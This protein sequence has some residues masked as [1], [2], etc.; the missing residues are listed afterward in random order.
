[1]PFGLF[2][3]LTLDEL[4]I[5]HQFVL[6]DNLSF[7]CGLRNIVR[8]FAINAQKTFFAHHLISSRIQDASS[9]FHCLRS[10]SSSLS[11][12]SIS[13]FVVT[14]MLS[15]EWLVTVSVAPLSTLV[16]DIIVQLLP[17]FI[18]YEILNSSILPIPPVTV[19]SFCRRWQK[20]ILPASSV[21][22]PD[23]DSYLAW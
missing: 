15:V 17:M 12:S 23:R 2:Y 4:T 21:P 7:Y 9:F 16:C 6:R 18:Y 3:S 13:G 8:P 11:F 10:F 5:H 14:G 19:K 22:A 20:P 1:M